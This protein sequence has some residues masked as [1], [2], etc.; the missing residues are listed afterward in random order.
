MF[1]YFLIPVIIIAIVF[2][3]ALAVFATPFATI[4]FIFELFKPR[5]TI[6][7]PETKKGGFMAFAIKNLI[8]NGN[9]AKGDKPN[10]K[11]RGSALKSV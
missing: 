9:F 3:F 5:Q 6:A 10:E 4:Y 2:L 7:E 11:S 1:K 8:N